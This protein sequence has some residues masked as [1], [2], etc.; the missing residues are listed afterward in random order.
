MFNSRIEIPSKTAWCVYIRKRCGKGI[1]HLSM[2]NLKGLE[3]EQRP[4]IR[5][6]KSA[7]GGNFDYCQILPVGTLY[8][9]TLELIALLL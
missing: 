4:G 9:L 8:V 1:M 6:K 2:S 5:Q 7:R 3:S